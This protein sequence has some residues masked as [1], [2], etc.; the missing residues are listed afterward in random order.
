MFGACATVE[1]VYQDD[2]FLKGEGRERLR[3][4]RQLDPG[5][6][7]LAGGQVLS[8]PLR[9]NVKL[10]LGVAAASPCVGLRAELNSFLR[11]TW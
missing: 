9:S 1:S 4:E 2:S 3:V 11:L 5:P 6:R 10:W 8:V 7:P